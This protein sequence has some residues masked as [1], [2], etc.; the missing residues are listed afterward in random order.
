[1]Q[2][3]LINAKTKYKK[4]ALVKNLLDGKN[5]VIEKFWHKS[6][7]DDTIYFD[8][9]S[10]KPIIVYQNGKWA[11]ILNSI[12]LPK[13]VIGG[14][15]YAENEEGHAI[16]TVLED[17]EFIIKTSSNISNFKQFNLVYSN[18]NTIERSTLN[19][20]RPA[21]RTEKEILNKS[22][23]CGKYILVGEIEFIDPKDLVTDECYRALYSNSLYDIVFHPT[24]CSYLSVNSRSFSYKSSNFLTLGRVKFMK[25]EG[26]EKDRLILCQKTQS[27]V[28]LKKQKGLLDTTEL[29]PGKYY[30]TVGTNGGFV[31]LYKSS[32]TIK[33][34]RL[35]DK[36]IL[37]QTVGYIYLSREATAYQIAEYAM[38]II[39]Q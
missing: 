10:G 1:M 19:I 27:Y 31:F 7:D 6:Q 28:E 3:L 13:L 17:G 37:E 2:D 34:L 11:N 20:L 22:K 38:K 14:D 25:L 21:T 35:M 12:S 23:D 30:E 29:I 9:N 32:G 39:H 16:F 18:E 15:Y 33:F 36:F 4:G 26:P 8:S 5:E 24:Q